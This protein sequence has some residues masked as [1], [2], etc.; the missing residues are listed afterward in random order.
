VPLFLGMFIKRTPSWSAWATLVIGFAVS[1][2]L[3]FL[4]KEDFIQNLFNPAVPFNSNEIGDLNIAITT[5][6]L[7]VVCVGTYLLS[8]LFYKNTS[9]EY[10][11]QVD[12]FFEQMNTPIDMETE[13]PGS[14]QGDMRQYGVLSSLC[15]VYGSVVLLLLLIPNKIEA[16]A[17]ILFSGGA[18]LIIGIILRII[19]KRIRVKLRDV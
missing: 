2:Q 7:M 19:A 13:H 18:I 12:K 8:M 1:I 4:L 11:R 9:E 15:M 5:A 14:K 10:R 6:T 3:R 16:R 17:C